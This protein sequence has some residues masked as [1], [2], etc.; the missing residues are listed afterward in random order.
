VEGFRNGDVLPQEQ[1][2]MACHI[3]LDQVSS[4]VSLTATGIESGGIRLHWP[5]YTKNLAGKKDRSVPSLPGER[6]TFTVALI[7]STN[8]FSSISERN[9]AAGS[10]MFVALL[11][12]LPFLR[13]L[14]AKKIS[15]RFLLRIYN[16]SPGWSNGFELFL[17]S[18]QVD[19]C[20]AQPPKSGRRSAQDV[21]ANYREPI[22]DSKQT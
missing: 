1:S 22:S 16:R 15:F 14:F 19:L 18:A 9:L 4:S 13:S 8:L 17:I 20:A 12:S 5:R 2:C 3:P 21:S 7:I 11:Q 6:S 10:A